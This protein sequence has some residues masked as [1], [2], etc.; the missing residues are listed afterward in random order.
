[1]IFFAVAFGLL[2]HAFFWGAGMAML[3]MPRP[4]RRFWPVLVFPAGF[5]LQSLIVW[6]GAY[7]NLRGT[8]AYAWYGE[9]VP[10][11]LLV[12]G[13]TRLGV[14]RS[15]TDLFRFGLVW[16]AAGGVLALLTLPLAVASRGLSSV[17]LGSCDAADYA[18]GA[19]T[20]MEFARSDRTGFLGLTEVVHIMS[21]DNFY[22]FWL[23]LN[24]FT[25]S[26]LMA[27][28]GSVFHCAPHELA[29]V[30][31]GVVLAASVPLVFWMARALFGYSGVAS[32]II[33]AVYGVSPITWY[34][35][36]QV[37]PAPLL[38]ANA[39]ALLN[40]AGVALWNGR[41][42]RAR[43]IQFGGVLL[44]A[45]AIVL[46]AYNFILI[47]GLAPA[48]TYVLVRAATQNDWKRL[49]GW[50]AAM[51]VPLVVAGL[52]FF[53]R[54][55]GL[56]ERFLLFQTYDFGW[57]IPAL[58]PEGWLGMV[59]GGDLRPWHWAGLRWLLA[60][61]FISGF[62]WALLRA[63]YERRWR[64]WLIGCTVVPVLAGYAFLEVRGIV[65][66]TNASYD[67]FKLFAV[68][69]PLLLPAFCWWITLRWSARLTDWFEVAVFAGIVVAFNLLGCGM[70]VYQLSRPPLMVDGE[71]R[72][73]RRV[74]SMADVQSVN[75]LI[76]DMWSRLWANE[77]LLRKPQYF[78]THTYEGRLNTPL[79][80][81][82]DLCSGPV[83]VRVPSGGSR[84]VTAH[85]W[86]VD[87]RAPDFVRAQLG[88][89]WYAEERLSN[90]DRWSWTRGEATVL[91]DNPGSR[92][93]TLVPTL[94]GRCVSPA[95]VSIA[96]ADATAVNAAVGAE[97]RA[98]AFAP[99]TVPP[100]H[101]TLV[102]RLQHAPETA[103]GDS[104]PLGVCVFSLVL[105][106]LK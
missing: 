44:V 78:A 1:M 96:I 92:P 43:A 20:F 93:V 16:A 31:T 103:N 85:Y 97:R 29:S 50:I 38:A 39:I 19:R 68:F 2:L 12:A 100:G 73:V 81:E 88:Q 104:R 28:N 37:S 60:T 59:M 53:A 74:E 4:W 9:L 45:Y 6:I 67:A 72:Q 86:L 22:E 63:T 87:T 102:M 71:L 94:D 30:I 57:R 11:I 106:P 76:P 14:R 91:L 56:V 27:L 8:N 95:A 83:R 3:T 10:M 5:A 23:K 51:A 64:V 82:W 49:L 21:A 7:V 58:L 79:R 84:D 33:A 35:F 70:Y 34:S 62:G 17:S 54:V 66:G 75:M 90:G 80:G 98:Y 32:L 52:I 99:I 18:A 65:K 42:S 25:P 89:G 61:V 105:A 55:S 46:G 15:R 36:A 26:A 77:F 13:I 40:W 69:Y 48:G 101:S 47:V 24:H 41:L